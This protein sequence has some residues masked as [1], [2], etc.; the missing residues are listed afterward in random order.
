[1]NWPV[2][3]WCASAAGVVFVQWCLVWIPAI[4][5]KSFD[6]AATEL[7]RTDRWRYGYVLGERDA[8]LVKTRHVA[9]ATPLVPFEPDDRESV[10]MALELRLGVWKAAGELLFYGSV[11]ALF[12]VGLSRLIAAIAPTGSR[13]RRRA[14][15]I[16]VA[17]IVGA[18]VVLAPYLI[19]GY[20]GEIFSSSPEL[21]P[22]SSGWLMPEAVL[23]RSV[24]YGYVLLSVCVLPAFT[25]WWAFPLLAPIGT[26]GALCII[27]TLV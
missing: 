10:A 11:L 4:D 19:A 16:A 12:T 15:A 21:V 26:G 20:G 25:A 7:Q 22:H 13:R 23:G 6:A 5:A 3:A 9:G 24:S 17:S 8:A 18:F 2:A 14:A 27:S 1:V